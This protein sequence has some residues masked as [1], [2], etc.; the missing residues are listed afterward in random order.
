MSAGR[1]C[2]LAIAL[3]LGLGVS[4]GAQ[5]ARAIFATG[6]FWSTEADFETLRGVTAVTSGYIGGHVQRPSYEQVGSGMSGHAE[7]VEVVYDPAKISYRELLAHF[8]R[9][10]DP[11]DGDGQFCDQGTMYRPSVFYL[12]ATQRTQAEASREQVQAG[13]DRPVLTHIARADLFWPAEATHQDFRRRHAERYAAYRVACGRDARLREV[14]G[15]VR[16]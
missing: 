10:H 12:D 6:C 14:W 3:G 2:A 15:E 11:F 16:R 9:T 4:G 5:A 8:W 7:A 13:L 1:A